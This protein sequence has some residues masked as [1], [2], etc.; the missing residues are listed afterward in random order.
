MKLILM[1]TND[2]VVPVFD[3]LREKHEIIS[4]FTRAPKPTGRKHILTK[5]PVH[6]W[7]E[8]HNI[9]VYHK[10]REF[11]NNG[12][13]FVVV[14]SYGVIIPDEILTRGTFINIHPSLL[15]KY[16]GPSPIKTAIINGDDVSGVCLMKMVS[17]CDAGDIYMYREFDITNDDTNKTVE[18]KVGKI[19]IE[20]LNEFFASPE[21]Y[22]PVAQ[23][24][25]PV[26]T[27]KFT[28]TDE[29]IDW[30]KSPNEIHNLVRAL[31]AGRTKINGIDVKILK[32]KIENGNLKIL[33]LQ[34]A[35]KKPM[36]WKSF[37]NGLHGNNI[38][39]GE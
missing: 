6:V 8:S 9:P 38:K 29:I 20:I 1:G 3:A 2:F 4:V 17:E 33:E 14:M 18:T 15:P 28:G 32:T 13:D 26:M 36:D 35:G 19:A 31:G 21:K 30:K 5:S 25:T 10:I 24:G 16:R 12:A 7:A 34:P 22:K 27:Y 23:T 37:V 39:F 11:E